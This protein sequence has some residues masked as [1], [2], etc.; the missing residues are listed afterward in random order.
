MSPGPGEVEWKA[1]GLTFLTRKFTKK[2]QK[3]DK[4]SKIDPGDNG[5]K[6]GQFAG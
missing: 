3:F 1:S 2:V 6:F 4:K 5:G